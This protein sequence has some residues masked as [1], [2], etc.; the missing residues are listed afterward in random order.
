[1]TTLTSS[2][3]TISACSAIP[4]TTTS[5]IGG[6]SLIEGTV[7]EGYKSVIQNAAAFSS[8][9]SN[10]EV[11][12]TNFVDSLR[13]ATTKTATSMTT[14]TSPSLTATTSL[15]IPS[16]WNWCQIIA[17]G[18]QD[19]DNQFRTGIETYSSQGTLI[20]EDDVDLETDTI[21]TVQ[22]DEWKGRSKFTIGC[23]YSQPD[24]T[25]IACQYDYEGTLYQGSVITSP[26]MTQ[27]AAWKE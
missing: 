2:C 17:F 23:V 9:L 15:S 24:A 3:H 6:D 19:S 27:H 12:I 5:T 14:T 13:T 18:V 7:T 10:P 8:L 25:F 26:G 1:M 21:I 16:S 20:Y 11:N 22:A 4:T